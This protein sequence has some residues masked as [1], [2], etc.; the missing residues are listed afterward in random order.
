MV[1]AESMMEEQTRIA[2]SDHV[3]ATRKDED[4]CKNC[5]Q[6]IARWTLP[7]CGHFPEHEAWYHVCIDPVGLRHF[8][9]HT[10]NDNEQ[11]T[12]YSSQPKEDVRI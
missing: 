4:V 7:Q 2:V 3:E 12:C 1:E 6:K 5:G 9:L 8:S 11:K 10:A